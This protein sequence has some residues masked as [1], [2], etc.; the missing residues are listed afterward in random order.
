MN[1]DFVFPEGSKEAIDKIRATVGRLVTINVLAGRIACTGVDCSYDPITGHST[2][3]FCLICDGL[4]W[5]ETYSGYL[6]SGHIRW[7]GADMDVRFTGGI[8]PFGDC[9][10]T[11]TYND[12]NMQ[13]VVDSTTWYVD[14]K[15]LYM[16]D[17]I[18]R[19][20]RGPNEEHVPNRIQ[21][22][23]RQE[24]RNAAG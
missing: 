10:V 6:V 12:K 5:Q 11:I 22:V 1:F 14:N 9:K 4:Y 7:Q 19:G 17:F 18:M 2:N 21:V 15:T 8:I 13:R 24:E 16:Q 3:S 23:L 20:I